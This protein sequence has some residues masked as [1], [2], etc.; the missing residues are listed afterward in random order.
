MSSTSGTITQPSQVVQHHDTGPYQY[1][2]TLYVAILFIVLF[3]ISTLVHVFQSIR[4]RMKWL[5]FTACFCGALEVAGW[6]GR[7]WSHFSVY[8]DPPFQLQICATIIGPTP[9]LAA[10][11]VIFGLIIQRLGASYSRL[12][13]KWYTILFCT[14]DVISLVVQGI[15]GGLAATAVPNGRDPRTGG[16]IML[17][18][19]IFQLVTI[20]VYSACATEFYI[21]YFKRRPIRL[22][23]GDAT[24]GLFDGRIKVMSLALAF[25][26][27]CLFIRAVY[28]TI[29]L[30]DGWTGRII[31]TQVYFNVLDGAMIVLAIYTLNFV[32]PGVFLAAKPALK[33]SDA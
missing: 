4:Y 20:T 22:D 18:G 26:T 27:T 17:G 29:E 30:S 25:N 6:S 19:I 16:N 24:H 28:R 8:L 7:L 33:T 11:F 32:H 15:G 14:C 23:S 21:R 2:P 10:N 9:L 13:P 1:V 3:S 12:S 31:G 5:L